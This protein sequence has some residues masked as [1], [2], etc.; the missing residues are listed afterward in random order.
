MGLR[1]PQ[2][3][4]DLVVDHVLAVGS[5]I[6]GVGVGSI[7]PDPAH[8]SEQASVAEPMPEHLHDRGVASTG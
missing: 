6:V 2:G 1:V 7:D 3:V 8:G 5:E 4:P